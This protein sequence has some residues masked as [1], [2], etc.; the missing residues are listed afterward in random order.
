MYCFSDAGAAHT[1]KTPL[2]NWPLHFARIWEIKIGPTLLK[3]FTWAEVSKS[4]VSTSKGS[5]A[6]SSSV[7]ISRKTGQFSIRRAFMNQRNLDSPLQLLCLATSANSFAEWDGATYWGN[8]VDETVSWLES[9]WQNQYHHDVVLSFVQCQLS[10]HNDRKL[11]HLQCSLMHTRKSMLSVENLC[12]FLLQFFIF[13]TSFSS[14][15]TVWTV[16]WNCR[17]WTD[18][19]F[20]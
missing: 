17:K 9:G 6:P 14:R 11:E 3:Y 1:A 16:Y 5:F 18:W 19:M 4:Y 10:N 13:N 12:F 15:Q 2:P 8:K 7:K 20:A